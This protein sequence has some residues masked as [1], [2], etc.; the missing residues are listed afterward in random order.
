[1]KKSLSVVALIATVMMLLAPGARAG[2]F[3]LFRGDRRLIAPSIAVG[4]ATT[5][6]YFAIRNQG[7]GVGRFSEGGAIGLSTVGCMA[8]TPLVSGIVVQR[9]L[10]RRE[11]HVMLANC[12]VPFIGGWLMDA[13]F[14]RH[15]DRDSVPPPVLVAMH[16]HHHH[17]YH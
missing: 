5:G 12:V 15:P 1:M 11:V 9:E 3:H 13:Y 14:D 16:H 17:H 7:G 8:L 6:A 4:A 2:E 10:T